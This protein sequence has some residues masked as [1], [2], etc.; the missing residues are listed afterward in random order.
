[1]FP[2]KSYTLKTTDMKYK[3]LP[4]VGYVI[5]SCCFNAIASRTLGLISKNPCYGAIFGT[6]NQQ[7]IKYLDN[8]I[9]D[10]MKKDL[11]IV[12]EHNK[13][14]IT[15]QKMIA[16]EHF[17]CSLSLLLHP[18]WYNEYFGIEC[19]QKLPF[20]QLILLDK[21][22]TVLLRSD[23]T[24]YADLI[25]MEKRQC[26]GLGLFS[27]TGVQNLIN[28][29][30]NMAACYIIPRRHGKTKFI[31]CLNG[32]CIT[33]F[34]CTKLKMLYVAQTKDLTIEALQAAIQMSTMLRDSF[35]RVQK[36]EYDKRL[37][38]QQNS[39]NEDF[40]YNVEVTHN[41]QRGTITCIFRKQTNKSIAN[42]VPPLGINSLACIVYQKENVSS[43]FFQK[44][45]LITFL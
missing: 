10:Y 40:Y 30:N 17:V 18:T 39:K 34:P 19:F 15:R 21:L 27:L 38:F 20:Q 33:L 23:M 13:F 36:E 24:E 11:I 22:V 28:Q 16:I 35:N 43:F 31:N 45:F 42:D 12:R 41:T 4:T 26:L 3:F 32:L 44:H 6:T 25:F 37:K 8:I 5:Q 7:S 1:M 14:N 9:E 2:K 29:L